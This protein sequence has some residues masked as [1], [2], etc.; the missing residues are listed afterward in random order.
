MAPENVLSNFKCGSLDGDE[1]YGLLMEGIRSPEALQGWQL[2][3]M[4]VSSG[5]DLVV[6]SFVQ[7]RWAYAAHPPLDRTMEVYQMLQV[8]FLLFL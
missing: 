3:V 6:A 5:G 7:L 8:G 4:T 2:V 1:G